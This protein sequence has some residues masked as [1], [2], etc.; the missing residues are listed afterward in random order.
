MIMTAHTSAG[1]RMVMV[2]KRLNEALA[3]PMELLRRYYAYVLERE[4]SLKQAKVMT[5]AQLAFFATVLPADYHFALRFV[6]CMWLLA[7]LKKCRALV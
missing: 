7:T 2:M 3:M 6:A 4:I 5:E 1:K